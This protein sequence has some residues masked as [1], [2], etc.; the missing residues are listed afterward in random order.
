VEVIAVAPDA[1]HDKLGRISKNVAYVQTP[2]TPEVAKLQCPKPRR[3]QR[4]Q[5][6]YPQV[7]HAGPPGP[8][9]QRHLYCQENQKASNAKHVTDPTSHK[10]ANV[11]H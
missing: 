2:P 9:Q 5:D 7:P 11:Q 1:Y 4:S 10:Q 8:P 6:K 3:Y